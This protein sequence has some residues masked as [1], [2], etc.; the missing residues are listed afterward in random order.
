LPKFTDEGKKEHEFERVEKMVLSMKKSV[1]LFL[2]TKIGQNKGMTAK[3]LLV[4]IFSEDRI[5][6]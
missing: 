4:S 3:M 5:N 2:S 6:D 1:M